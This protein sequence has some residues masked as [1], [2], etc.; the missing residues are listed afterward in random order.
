MLLLQRKETFI[1]IF[2]LDVFHS[3]IG[4]QKWLEKKIIISRIHLFFC[5]T[6]ARSTSIMSFDEQAKKDRKRERIN[7]WLSVPRHGDPLYTKFL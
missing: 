5:F 6:K 3:S 1:K 7:A 2:A 4:V